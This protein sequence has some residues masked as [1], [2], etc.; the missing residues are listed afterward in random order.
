MQRNV[1]LDR[2]AMLILRLSE[3]DT[4]P[5]VLPTEPWRDKNFSQSGYARTT[6]THLT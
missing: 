5:D 1:D 3:L 6:A 4:T 2:I